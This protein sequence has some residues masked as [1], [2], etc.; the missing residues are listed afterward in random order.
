MIKFINW[1][2]LSSKDSEKFSLTIKGF[3]TAF[4]TL[5]TVVAGFEHVQLSSADLTAVVDAAVSL[6]QVVCLAVST[7]VTLYG[8]IRKVVITLKGENA[9]LNNPLI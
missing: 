9:V 2:V 8:A 3:G 1:I 4:M 7:A 5:L 6:L